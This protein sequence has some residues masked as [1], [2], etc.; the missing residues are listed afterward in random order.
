M[1]RRENSDVKWPKDSWRKLDKWASLWTILHSWFADRINNSSLISRTSRFC[2]YMGAGCSA[3]SACTS[4]TNSA[5]ESATALKIGQA[6]QRRTAGTSK[7]Y[8]FRTLCPNLFPLFPLRENVASEQLHPLI[9]LQCIIHT[10]RTVVFGSKPKGSGTRSMYVDNW[11]DVLRVACF[12]Y[13]RRL[14]LVSAGIKNKQAY[15][16]SIIVL[17]WMNG[18]RL[19]NSDINIC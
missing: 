12:S 17:W 1:G 6:N 3:S 7:Y 8:L 2:L 11:L 13:Q 15:M 19:C 10:K 18:C 16:N 14:R 4:S 9:S 5:F